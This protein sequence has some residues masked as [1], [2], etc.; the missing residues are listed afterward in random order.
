MRQSAMRHETSRNRTCRWKPS[1]TPETKK[2]TWS[3]CALCCS[4]ATNKCHLFRYVQMLEKWEFYVLARSQAF[5][6]DKPL[7][8]RGSNWKH[9]WCRKKTDTATKGSINSFSWNRWAVSVETVE[10]E[11]DEQFRL[12]NSWDWNRWAVSVEEQLRLK[13][14]SS[15]GW[16]TVETEAD[17]QFGLKNS[18]DWNRWAVSVEDS[19]GI[20]IWGVSVKKQLRLKQMSSKR[21]VG[22]L[23]AS[24]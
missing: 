24:E 13:Q 19:W 3:T 20:N 17:E 18:C 6:L 8:D 12:Q 7:G 23:P 5:L 14:L 4:V 22:L 2:G 10:T 1:S 21:K 9:T 11:T 15:F 16:N